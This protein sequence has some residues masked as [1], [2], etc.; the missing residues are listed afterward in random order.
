MSLHKSLI[1]SLDS[2]KDIYRGNREHGDWMYQ[3]GIHT[4]IY[5][6]V[7]NLVDITEVLLYIES[8]EIDDIEVLLSPGSLNITL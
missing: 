5:Y 7:N 2:W 4:R 8:F 3:I 6:N 1:E